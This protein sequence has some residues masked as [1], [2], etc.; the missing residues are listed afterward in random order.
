VAEIENHSAFVSC[1]RDVTVTA[2]GARFDLC[3]QT[4][5]VLRYSPQ[6][7]DIPLRG[8]TAQSWYIFFPR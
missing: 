3:R 2:E 4:D 8:R 6:D 5:L 1:E 7:T